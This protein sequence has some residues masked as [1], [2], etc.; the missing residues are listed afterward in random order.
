[1][2]GCSRLSV[3]LTAEDV[4]A[5]ARWLR[6]FHAARV[7]GGGESAKD[8]AE[9]TQSDPTHV[10]R[11]EA[12]GTVLR[13]PQPTCD[14]L[15]AAYERD[16]YGARALDRIAESQERFFAGKLREL[17]DDLRELGHGARVLEVGS[18]VGGF[19]KAARAHGWRAFG[20]DVGEETTS[21]QRA[22]ALDV[23]RG[24]IEAAPVPGTSL[25][26]V[27]VWNTFDQLC[28]PHPVLERAFALSR[29]G[30][31]LVLR[32]PNGRFESACVELRR[33]ARRP[34]RAERVLRAQAYNNFVTFPYLTG[35]TPETLAAL[36]R[37]HG[38]AV[39]RVHGDTILTLAGDDTL[40]FAVREEEY[41]KR[42][43]SRACDRALARCGVVFHPWMD[44]VA[45][46]DDQA[47]GRASSRM[48]QSTHLVSSS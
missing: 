45:V 21:Y 34:G 17:A 46:R 10:V 27:F 4:V 40:P 12:C 48:R 22:A 7:R 1:V 38:F 23:V 37:G 41:V 15:A 20:V 30:A 39:R 19:L 3:L 43:V 31:L 26:A 11:C 32:V 2:C 6:A 47:D 18:F 16:E 13:D 9:F 25:D 28:D 8:R 44:V 29:P 36:L 35:Y 33:H 14:A 42:G 5:E 24:G